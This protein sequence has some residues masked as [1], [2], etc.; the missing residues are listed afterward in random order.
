M[1]KSIIGIFCAITVVTVTFY[2][3]FEIGKINMKDDVAFEYVK[4]NINHFLHLH[5]AE[6]LASQANTNFPHRAIVCLIGSLSACA[7][8]KNRM[9]LQR[10]EFGSS[11]GFNRDLRKAISVVCSNSLGSFD[12]INSHAGIETNSVKID[13]SFLLK[14]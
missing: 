9:K 6:K 3:G 13:F 7:D 12:Y 4:M 2:A 11:R 8:M 5:E 1:K 10:Q 14:E